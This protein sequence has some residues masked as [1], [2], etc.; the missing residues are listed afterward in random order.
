M[1]GLKMLGRGG[2]GGGGCEFPVSSGQVSLRPVSEQA[3]SFVFF[4]F[5]R[6]GDG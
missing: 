1:L 2:G 3:F 4:F 6:G 5:L